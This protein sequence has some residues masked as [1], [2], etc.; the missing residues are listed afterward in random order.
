M[1]ELRVATRRSALALAQCRAFAARLCALDPS[2]V[3]TEVHVV[4]SGDKIQDRSLADIGGK[5]LFVKEIE[6]A[7]LEERADFAVHS[8]KDMPA[9]L[10]PG[11]VVACIPSREDPRDALVSSGG[12]RLRELS[13]GARIGTSSLRRAEAL[14]ALRPDVTLLPMRGNVD[15]RLR[16]LADGA[17]DAI[18]LALAGLRRLGLEGRATEILDVDECI[19]APGQGALGIECRE[20]DGDLR[21]LLRRLHD[22][23]AGL[24][25]S[26][27]RAVLTALGGDCRTPLGAHARREPAGGLALAAFVVGEAEPRWREARANEPWPATEAAAAEVGTR[28]ASRLSG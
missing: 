5:G 3:V 4:T 27:E 10:A 21:T 17:C 28:L 24:C 14:R 2:L 15:T 19:P 20:A 8:M 1:K 23:E 6:E 9:A 25:V 11:L 22:D 18:V 7:L 12:L 13:P 26:A 16:R